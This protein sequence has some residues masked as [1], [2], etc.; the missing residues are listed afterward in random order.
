MARCS[1]ITCST[2]DDLWHRKCR[3]CKKRFV[4]KVGLDVHKQ[5]QKEIW[6]NCVNNKLY[7]IYETVGSVV[8]NKGLSRHESVIINRLRIG[9]TIL[10]GTAAIHVHTKIQ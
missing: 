4:T 1:S 2:E 3:I 10:T 9:H 8:H 5:I 7:A 6:S